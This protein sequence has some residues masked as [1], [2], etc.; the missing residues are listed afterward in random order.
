MIARLAPWALGAAAIAAAAIVIVSSGGGATKVYLAIPNGD[1]LKV[2][3]DVKVAGTAVGSVSGLGFDRN[4][5]VRVTMSVDNGKAK[6]GRD[7][8]AAIRAANLLGQKFIALNLGNP[9]SPMPDGGT[10]PLSRVSFPTDLDEVLD[11]LDPSTRARLG[12]LVDE[13]GTAL[14]G[15][16]ADFNALLATA[17]QSIARAR[18]IVG[19][20]AT[21]NGALAQ[22]VQRT[23]GWV[24]KF[25]GQRRQLADLVSAAG[26]TMSTFAARRTEL[27]ATLARAPGALESGR[28]FLADLQS[29]AQPLAPAARLIS[30]TAPQLSR[31]LALLPAFATT[32][33]PALRE[34]TQ[35]APFLTRVAAITPTVRLAAPAAASLDTLAAVAPPATQ[36]LGKSI[37]DVM[38][39]IE[40]WG[41][42]AQTRDA[43][44]HVFR[45]FFD[46]NGD[47]L[48]SLLHAGS[49]LVTASTRAARPHAQTA[50]PAA[51]SPATG[52]APPQGGT[53]PAQTEPVPPPGNGVSSLLHFLLGR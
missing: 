28:T 10:I 23:N 49:G 7:A 1:G 3:A 21:N 44:G 29:A 33:R 20:L 4:D 31:F 52:P 38:A 39:F 47:V 34:A 46:L 26:A 53:G 13:A 22:L 14:T 48:Q 15:R 5:H 2:G 12:I 50:H 35:T 36:A 25:S 37:D 11:V 42:A 32:A 16:R 18:R 45:G 40:G 19:D 8:S 9:A 51:A 43:A 41:R 6:V 24:T 17:P 30:S 27:R